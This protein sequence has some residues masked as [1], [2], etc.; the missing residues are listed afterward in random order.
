MGFWWFMLLCSLLTPVLMIVGG[1]LMWK[2]CPKKINHFIGYRTVRSMK[3]MDTW[4][5]AHEHIGR[6]WW[7]VGWILLWPTFSLHLPIYGASESV[8]G[9][10]GTVWLVIQLIVLLVSILPTER[11][12]KNTFHDDGSRK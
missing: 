9:V 7:K 5:F 10:A 11:A 1:R 4:T 8:V 12:L 6:T 3:N 2:R